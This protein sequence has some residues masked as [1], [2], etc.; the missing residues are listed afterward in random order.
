[1]RRGEGPTTKEGY[2]VTP[3]ELKY[4]KLAS[5]AE[6]VDRATFS[7]SRSLA[8]MADFMRRYY[9]QEAKK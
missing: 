4:L 8:E 3:E 5:E 6:G 7:R 1:M 9:A 2:R